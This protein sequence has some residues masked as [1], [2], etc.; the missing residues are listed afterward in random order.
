MSRDKVAIIAGASRGIGAGTVKLLAENGYLV[1]ISHI[2]ND[3][4]AAGGEPNRVGRLKSKIP[5]KRDG[6]PKEV[7]EAILWI[8]TEISSLVTGSFIDPEGGL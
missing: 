2:S 7:A 8:A 5:L 6:Q 3:V 1:F 4:V